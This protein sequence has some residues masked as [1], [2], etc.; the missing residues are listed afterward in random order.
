MESAPSQHMPVLFILLFS[1]LSAVS[2]TSEALV[3]NDK[4]CGTAGGDA[5]LSCH[6]FPPMNAEGMQVAWTKGVEEES[7]V[8]FYLHGMEHQEKQDVRYRGRTKMNRN[9]LANGVMAVT[10]HNLTLS[11]AGRY[12]CSFT[13]SHGPL[14]T[15]SHLE[16]TV[17][18]RTACSLG[19][20]LDK[21][22]K[23]RDALIR[24]RDYLQRFKD[25]QPK[26]SEWR[27]ARSFADHITMDPDTANPRLVVSEG[28]TSV[29]L[30]DGS[31]Q[32]LPD[33]SARFNRSPC[34]LGRERLTSGRHYWEVEV[35]QVFWEVGVCDESVSRKGRRTPS[36][37]GGCWAVG[38]WSEQKY[39]AFTSPGTRLSPTVAPNVL[40][41]FLDLDAGRI[42]FYN[43]GD[44][45]QFYTFPA[46]HFPRPLLPYLCTYDSGTPLRLRK[47]TAQA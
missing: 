36:P 2:G 13:S 45:S 38:L 12:F 18:G 25:F 37:Q 40:G 30:L 41:V 28:G 39:W 9:G 1:L 24:E 7:I 6:L 4:I 8:H 42:L 27:W 26:D 44:K 14:N 29:I 43:V 10:I 15:S 32:D 23:E 20:E 33:T 17:E 47:L 46:D 22:I 31:E 34:V 21:L 5:T 35:G 11:D 16:V 19:T 3:H